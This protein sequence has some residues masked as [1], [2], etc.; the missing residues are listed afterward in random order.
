MIEPNELQKLDQ[1]IDEMLNKETKESLN[2]HLDKSSNPVMQGWICPRCGV[3][4]SPFSMQCYCKPPIKVNYGS[5]TTY[6][7]PDTKITGAQ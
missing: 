1:E 5:G 2:E 3:V 4:H 6:I 7:T